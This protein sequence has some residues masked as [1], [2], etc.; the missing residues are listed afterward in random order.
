MNYGLASANEK[1]IFLCLQACKMPVVALLFCYGIEHNH[2]RHL[3]PYRAYK[4]HRSITAKLPLFWWL[5]FLLALCPR[6]FCALDNS[7]PVL[8][9]VFPVVFC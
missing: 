6:S 2:I 9:V 8:G 3:K 7:I 4:Q 1:S 5:L